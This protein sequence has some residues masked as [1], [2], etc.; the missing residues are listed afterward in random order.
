[1]DARR[2]K[3]LVT[4]V[5][6][7]LALLAGDRARSEAVAVPGGSLVEAADFERHVANLFTRL[8]CNAGSCHGSA[9]GK[10][11]AASEPLW[12]VAGAG[13]SRGRARK[14]GPAR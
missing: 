3:S 13:L 6:V 1:M 9:K 11:G 5:W 14:P 4:P 8:G 7:G 10:G 12:S 2:I